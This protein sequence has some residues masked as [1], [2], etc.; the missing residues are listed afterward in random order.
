M[1]VR[2]RSAIL[3][4][5]FISEGMQCESCDYSGSCGSLDE[6]P[7]SDAGL[8][9]RIIFWISVSVHNAC[10]VACRGWLLR[11]REEVWD[12]GVGKKLQAAARLGGVVARRH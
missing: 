10:W 3:S 2:T 1:N 9:G 5:Q 12:S 4:T 6:S 8:N 7:A 11:W